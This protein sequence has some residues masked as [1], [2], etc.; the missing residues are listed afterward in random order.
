VIDWRGEPEGRLE[1]PTK[2][3][4]GR[5]VAIGADDIQLE[6]YGYVRD[7]KEAEFGR[8]WP[9]ATLTIDM[10]HR[11]RRFD[12]MIELDRTQSPYQNF[13]KFRRYDALITGWWRRLER[14]R[15][16]GE[17]P[18]AVFVCVDEEHVE[19]FARAANQEMTGRL[20]RTG[21]S[22]QSWPYPGR[23]RTLFVSER[24]MHE[25]SWRAW[26]LPAEPARGRG[27]LE[28]REVQLPGRK[29]GGA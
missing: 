17:P 14:Y 24:D 19:T 3:H 4:E 10:P 15:K 6:R 8:V 20:A 16:L 21:T 13:E 1:A 2:L 12:L 18:A 11:G 29:G 5:R 28:L 23:E 22:E 9:D 25:G 26:K 27:A 7:L